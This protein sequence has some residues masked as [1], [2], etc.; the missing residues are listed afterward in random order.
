MVAATALGDW[1]NSKGWR[2]GDHGG[3]LKRRL[4][5]AHFIHIVLYDTAE[6]YATWQAGQLQ[7][8]R[9]TLLS[10]SQITLLSFD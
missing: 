9:F 4:V 1:A 2:C 6:T 3:C 7:Q 8:Q 10:P 5:L